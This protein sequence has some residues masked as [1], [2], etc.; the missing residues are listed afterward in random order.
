MVEEQTLRL[1]TNL[2]QG[3]MSIMMLMGNDMKKYSLMEY[4]TTRYLSHY[5][6]IITI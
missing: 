3:C 5:I 6:N 1:N 4:S 2:F